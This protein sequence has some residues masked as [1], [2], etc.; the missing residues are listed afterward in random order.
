MQPETNRKTHIELYPLFSSITAATDLINRALVGHHKKVAFVAAAIG[1][2]LGLDPH[3]LIRLTLAAAVHDIGGVSIRTRLESF[4]FEVQNPDRHTVPGWCLLSGFAPF[5]DLARLVR[6]HHVDWQNGQGAMDRG[7]EVPLLSH[8][9][10]ISDRIAVQLDP[11]REVLSQ[12]AEIIQRIKA[13][14]GEMFVPEQVEAFQ[15]VAGKEA[16][17]LDLIFAPVRKILQE[18][19]PFGGMDLERSELLDLVEMFRRVIDLRSRFTAT[20]SSGVAAVADAIAKH[21]GFQIADRNK[22]EIAGLLHDIGKLVVP[23]EI[24]E[25]HH[26]LTNEDF[27]VIY[28]H[29]YFSAEILHSIEGFEEIS[30][31]GALHHERLDGT[32]YPYRKAGKEIPQGARILAVA[33]TFTA[34]MEDRP[35]RCGISAVST[36]RIMRDMADYRKLDKEFV[37]LIHENIGEINDRRYEAQTDADRTHMQFLEECQLLGSYIEADDRCP[38]R[39]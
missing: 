8:I 14:S 23:A 35:Y 21:S 34:L 26:V 22:M 32:G 20:H 3:S 28:K 15:E 4:A 16:F 37:D 30:R 18:H 6:F 29:P 39:R 27:A 36:D 12:K 19:F 5:A 2:A 24:L 13:G 38:V 33:D 10:H 31:W 7:E 17:W 9:I 1:K 11:N 25:K